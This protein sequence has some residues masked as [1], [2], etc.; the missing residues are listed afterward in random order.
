MFDLLY[1]PYGRQKESILSL[2]H[3]RNIDISILESD[4]EPLILQDLLNGHHLLAIDE[5]S[6]VNH[7]KRPI[8][9][10]LQRLFKKKKKK[11]G[12]KE[13]VTSYQMKCKRFIHIA[14]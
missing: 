2:D 12:L 1:S 4:L 5:A 11:K 8:T 10:H 3:N 13:L 9:N 14:R 7:T 6:L